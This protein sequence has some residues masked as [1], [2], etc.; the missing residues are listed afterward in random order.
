MALTYAARY[1]TTEAKLTAY[2]Q[3]KLHERGWAD[4]QAPEPDALASEFASLG[5]IND[6]LYAES[7]AAALGRRG[8]GKMRVKST[9]RAAGISA[10]IADPLCEPKAGE[11][12][13]Q[14]LQF[15]ARKRIAPYYEGTPDDRLRKRWLGALIRAGHSQQTAYRLVKLSS[16]VEAEQALAE[17]D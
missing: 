7:K 16:S 5:Y 9:L 4:D 10:D 11:D 17:F 13:A 3:R 2:L 6:Q 8:L 14:A 15:A 12:F 1:A